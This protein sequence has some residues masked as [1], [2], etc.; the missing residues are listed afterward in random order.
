LP[1]IGGGQ[2]GLATSYHL[3]ARGIEHVVLERRRVGETWRSRRWDSF[4]LITPNWT[5]QLPGHNYDGE[6]PYGFM[7]RAQIV[8]YLERYAAAVSAPLREDVNV[9]RMEPI[10]D[11]GFRLHLNGEVLEA[12]QVVVATGAFQSPHRAGQDTS[13]HNG[14]IFQLHTDAYRNPDALPDGAVLMVGSGQSGCQIAE[15]LQLSGRQVYLAAGSC[16]WAHR[17]LLGHDIAWW[18]RETGFYERT[19][20]QLP[21][22]PNK[23]ACNPQ[24]TG[25]DGGRDLNLRTLAAIGVV[26]TGRLRALVDHKAVIADDLSES[27]AKGDLFW[28]KLRQGFE[29][30]A[31]SRG[32]SVPQAEGPLPPVPDPHLNELDLSAHGVRSVIWANGYR[33]D[34][35]WIDL[36]IFHI[37][38]YPIHKRGVSSFPGLYFVGLHW[39]HKPKS[40]LLYGVGEDAEYIAAAI[41]ESAISRTSP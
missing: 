23:F 17:E 24:V 14:K 25:E 15:E 26:I 28:A 22:P 40:A 10:D 19:A 38:G 29:D 41:D 13:Q 12:S 9:S 11:S 31:R 18:L 4:T 7:P 2:A 27:V 34:F 30:Y 20:D 35:S 21:E 3:T 8:A 5:V 33:P 32:L 16:G 6:A 1:V 36:P 37:D 39:L